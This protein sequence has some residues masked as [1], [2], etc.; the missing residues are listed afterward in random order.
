MARN[1]WLQQAVEQRVG[2]GLGLLVHLLGHEIVE[3]IFA[4]GVEVP[5]DVQRGRLDRLAVDGGDRDRSGSQ[6]GYLVVIEDEEVMG[7][8]QDGR[9]IRG[10]EGG[11]LGDPHDE[12]RDPAGG[13]N[14]VGVVGVD[15]GE[16]EGTTNPGQGGPH[17]AAQAVVRMDG[18]VGLDEMGQHFGV[19]LRLEPVAVGDELVGQ[20][21]V[22]LDDA[23]VHQS[24]VARAVRV[25]VG[26]ALARPAVGRPPGVAD[27]GRGMGRST[28]SPLDQVVKRTGAV[29][30]PDPPGAV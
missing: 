25:R 12:R 4:G 1:S 15:H 18:Q 5:V 3:A 14:D 7:D 28:L 27:A 10:Q 24:Q 20:L 21:D 2:H 23:V 9:D 11:P 8:S 13:H 16:G 26:V 17:R 19:R 30:R 6:L 29:C 22:V